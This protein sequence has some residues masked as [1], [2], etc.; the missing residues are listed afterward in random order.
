VTLHQQVIIVS[1]P[2]K[3]I[4]DLPPGLFAALPAGVVV[5]DTGNYYP[6]LRDGVIPGLEEIGI[7]TWW[8]Q[9]VGSLTH[10]GSSPDR[11]FTA[12]TSR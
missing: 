3:N 2:E 4:P 5:I 8:V 10:G 7:D 6:T 11:P 12:G 1:I 9:Q